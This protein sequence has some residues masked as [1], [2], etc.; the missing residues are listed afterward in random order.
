MK[1]N[2]RH[3]PT[4]QAGF[5]LV[6]IMVG[7]VIG[8]LATLVIVQIMSVFEAQKRTTTGSADAQTNGAIALFT[9][10][11]E[12][13]MGGFPI[14]PTALTESPFKCATVRM[15]GVAN[16]AAAVLLAPVI[17][18]DGGG[19]ASDTISIRYGSTRAG[20]VPTKIQALPVG[21]VVTVATN[22]GCL[23]GDT[24]LISNSISTIC[25]L[26][27]VTT[28]GLPGATIPPG[29]TITLADVTGVQPGSSLA[30]L[31][32]WPAVAPISFSVN[33]G[34]LIQN[35]N[36]VV[37]GIVNIQAQYGIS[38]TT[39]SNVIVKWVDGN[40]AWAP[41]A[42]TVASRNLIK[43][44][45]IAV[46]AQN[47]KMDPAAVTQTCSS[48]TTPNPTGLCAW[49]G[50]AA[51]PAPLINMNATIP[52][53]LNYRYRVFETIIPVRNIIWSWGTL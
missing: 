44:V 9:I 15:N 40:G 30:C 19:N 1:L 21:N 4:Y 51:D 3:S 28:G 17:I 33:N 13:K 43:A 42:L 5:S 32:A 45:R 16:P 11:H 23:N 18:T 34:N 14:M 37:A 31:G 49:E 7:L 27:T 29:N 50:T 52:N 12:L 41:G 38:A 53:W 10:E 46:V 24:S 48:P 25:D 35:G 8:L 47:P 39:N 2:M 6:E 22:F 20:G 26:S 36:N